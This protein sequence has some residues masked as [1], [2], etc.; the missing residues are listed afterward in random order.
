MKSRGFEKVSFIDEGVIP[1]RSTQKSAGYDF[2]AIEDAVVYPGHITI[3]KTGIKAYMLNDEYLKL[4]IRSSMGIKK[5][6]VLANTIG[7]I[8]SDYYNNIDNEGHIMIAL[9]NSSD[10]EQIIKKN[11]KLAQGIFQKYL[12]TDDDDANG[13]RRGGIGSTT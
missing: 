11:Q 3:F 12:L 1:K 8:D 2:Y 10:K 6:L 5:G 9:F 7:I 4:V 13:V